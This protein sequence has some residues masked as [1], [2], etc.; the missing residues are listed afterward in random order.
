MSSL[1][2]VLDSNVIIS[3]FLFGGPPAR[4]LE[5]AITGS[6]QCFISL[7]ILDEIR[8]VLLRPK[9]G[10]SSNQALALIGE[11][12]EL[13]RI[14]TPKARIRVVDADPDDNMILECASAADADV[15]VSGDSHLLD[16]GQWRGIR[17][18]P[19]ADFAKEIQGQPTDR[20]D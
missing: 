18:H 10:L 5:H 20:C 16:L 4:L 14:V 17:I 9:F 8:D 6:L 7:P 3:G 19:P 13:C 2:M 11:L 12:H 15:I 1:R